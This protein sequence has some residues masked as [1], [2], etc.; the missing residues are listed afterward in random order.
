[1]I[2]E[3]RRAGLTINLKNTQLHTII[4][5]YTIFNFFKL[6]ENCT[7]KVSNPLVYHYLKKNAEFTLTLAID[8]YLKELVS[9]EIVHFPKNLYLRMN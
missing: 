3:L 5:V 8:M 2:T 4:Y 7:N 6:E 9:V 1:M